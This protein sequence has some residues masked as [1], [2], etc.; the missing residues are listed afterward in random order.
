[1]FDIFHFCDIQ[2][3]VH[4]LHKL[5]DLTIYIHIKENTKMH[6]L[7]TLRGFC[8]DYLNKVVQSIRP[9]KETEE[10]EL[11]RTIIIG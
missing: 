8:Y 7:M 9:D 11:N 3:K 10:S 2:C 4:W 6:I 1:M 5:F